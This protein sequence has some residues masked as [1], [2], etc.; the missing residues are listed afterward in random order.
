M[1]G[2]SE[3]LREEGGTHGNA[4][5]DRQKIRSERRSLLV[6]LRCEFVLM[7]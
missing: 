5:S 1:S 6:R 2:D 3:N 4:L 7:G